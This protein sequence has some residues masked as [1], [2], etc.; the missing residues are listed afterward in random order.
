M[1]QK[2]IAQNCLHL[3]VWNPDLGLDPA[4]PLQDHCLCNLGQLYFSESVL[5][6]SNDNTLLRIHS[7]DTHLLRTYYVPGIVLYSR[8]MTINEA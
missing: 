8:D 3:G 5:I 2:D 1:V 6:F 7:S 4:T